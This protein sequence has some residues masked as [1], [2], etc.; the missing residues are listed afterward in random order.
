MSAEKIEE[1]VKANTLKFLPEGY[2]WD[3]Y[4]YLDIEGNKLPEHPNLQKLIQWHLDKINEEIGKYN[5][6]VEKEKKAFEKAYY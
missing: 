2:L 5:R 1:L 4:N 6:K 3:G